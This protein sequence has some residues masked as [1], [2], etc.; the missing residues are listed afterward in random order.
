MRVYTHEEEGGQEV[1]TE[2]GE[3]GSNERSN[4]RLEEG[5]SNSDKTV[6]SVQK[7]FHILQKC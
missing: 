2:G 3:Y 7:M 4:R 1:D 5:E 6:L